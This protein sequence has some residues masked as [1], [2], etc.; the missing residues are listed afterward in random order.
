M[1]AG[2][3]NYR[4]ATCHRYQGTGVCGEELDRVLVLPDRRAAVV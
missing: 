3:V 4:H 1:A 2:R